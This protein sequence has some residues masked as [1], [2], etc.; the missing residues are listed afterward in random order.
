MPLPLPLN[1]PG[2]LLAYLSKLHAFKKGEI[3][4]ATIGAVR[5]VLR[6]ED[7]RIL[8]DL[9]EKSTSLLLTP[10][11]ADDRALFARNAQA[12]IA[13]DLRRIMSDENE[14][15]LDKIG[16]GSGRSDG[17]NPRRR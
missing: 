12:F 7:G 15:L 5:A 3:A 16:A 10:I 11:L 13:S 1:E 17:G 6:T 4:E 2:P 9:L 14:Q 8:L